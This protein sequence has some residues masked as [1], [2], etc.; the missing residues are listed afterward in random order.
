MK[1]SPAVWLAAALIP[2]TITGCENAAE[3]VPIANAN[4]YAASS[5]YV[6]AFIAMHSAIPAGVRS[7]IE[8][9]Q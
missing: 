4:V 6:S 2:L 5:T 1:Q 3:V 8:E 7:D 9:Y